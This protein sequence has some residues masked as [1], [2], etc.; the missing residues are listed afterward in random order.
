MTTALMQELNARALGVG[1]PFQAH[2]WTLLTAVTS[3]VCTATW[4][5]MTTAR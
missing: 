5:M 1:R 2:T 4:I 3:A